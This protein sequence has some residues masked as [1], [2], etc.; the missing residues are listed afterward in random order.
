VPTCKLDALPALEAPPR[1][2]LSALAA[3]NATVRTGQGTNGTP[4]A[5][6]LSGR[7]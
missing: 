1:P 5:G 3:W 2:S 4:L 7:A 6:S